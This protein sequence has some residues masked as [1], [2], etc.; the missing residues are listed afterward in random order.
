MTEE[1]SKNFSLKGWRFTEWLKRNK[2]SIKTI[3]TILL[4]LLGASL[5]DRPTLMLLFGS[6]SAVGCRLILDTFDYFVSEVV[7][8]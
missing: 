4:G 2:D 8:E 1:I 6:V 3:L 5:S 7:I